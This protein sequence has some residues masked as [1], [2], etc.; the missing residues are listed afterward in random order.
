MRRAIRLRYKFIGS[1]VQFAALLGHMADA[2]HS[3]SVSRQAGVLLETPHYALPW[4]R[5]Y[6][7]QSERLSPGCGLAVCDGGHRLFVM[8]EI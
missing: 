1:E 3:R 8:Q 6:F 7:A 5:L 2:S 4:G